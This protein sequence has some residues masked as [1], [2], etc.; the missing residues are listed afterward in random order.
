MGVPW[1]GVLLASAPL[2]NDTNT[3]A[4][5][6]NTEVMKD[7]VNELRGVR[8]EI[9]SVN[10][11][12]LSRRA[13]LREL[14][15]HLVQRKPALARFRGRAP[16]PPLTGVAG[17]R[18]D[19][20]IWH[21]AGLALR[22]KPAEAKLMRRAALGFAAL[23]G[24]IFLHVPTHTGRTQ[25]APAPGQSSLS[26]QRGTLQGLP[27][28][29]LELLAP[30]PAQIGDV[31]AGIQ[32]KFNTTGVASLWSYAT[33]FATP[34]EETCNV[35]GWSGKVATVLMYIGMLVLVPFIA[36]GVD[37]FVGKMQKQ[38]STLERPL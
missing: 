3:T 34:V 13:E 8:T 20:E 22:V 19:V 1:L 12:L 10:T 17:K 38:A 26:T 21:F 35:D 9:S 6:T 11:E 2:F 31:M 18:E 28:H 4:P 30:A 37:L 14:T 32:Q 36:A 33:N 7:L 23:L 16:A 24:L 15:V 27:P 29:S 5:Q 25:S